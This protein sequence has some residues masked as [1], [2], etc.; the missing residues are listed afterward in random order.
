MEIKINASLGKRNGINFN[1]EEQTETVYTRSRIWKTKLA[2]LAE[3]SIS[4]IV[5]SE[6][7]YGITYIIPKKWVRV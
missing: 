4:V 1:E 7:D 2:K 3:K 6:D 5:E